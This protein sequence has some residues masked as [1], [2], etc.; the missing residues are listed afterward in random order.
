MG[1]LLFW[2]KID[3]PEGYKEIS[4]NHVINLIEASSTGTEYDVARV[5]HAHF[6]DDYKCA[7]F[8]N[9][10]WFRYTSHVWEETDRGVHLQCKLSTEIWEI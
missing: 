6:R 1:S 9:N 10:V 8:A 2:S 3:N 7:R 4:K 5:V